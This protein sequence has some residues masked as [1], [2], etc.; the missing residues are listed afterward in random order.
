MDERIR[1][2]ARQRYISLTTYRRDCRAVATPVWFVL[3]GTRILV[4]TDEASG[5]AKRIR[6]TGR[7]SVAPSDARGKLTGPPF[8]A[9]GREYHAAVGGSVASHAR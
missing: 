6:A 9:K 1:G 2:L 7:A 8:D 3:D 5:K 4:W